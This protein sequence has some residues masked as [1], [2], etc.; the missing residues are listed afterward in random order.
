MS[1]QIREKTATQEYQPIFVITAVELSARLYRWDADSQKLLPVGENA[2]ELRIDA[3]GDREKVEDFI[4]QMK[5][6]IDAAVERMDELARLAKA[7][8]LGKEE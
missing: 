6:E 7:T 5:K 2:G 3:T 8:A 4:L 1:P